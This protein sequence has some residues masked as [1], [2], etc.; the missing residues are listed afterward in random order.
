MRDPML[1]T[2][3]GN[4]VYV[5]LPD[6]TETDGIVVKPFDMLPLRAT[7]LNNGQPLETSVDMPASLHREGRKYLRVRGLPVNEITGETLIIKLEFDPALCE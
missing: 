4:T 2:R 1:L 7:L 5:H 6:D 3:R